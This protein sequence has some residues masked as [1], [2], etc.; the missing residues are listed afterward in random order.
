MAELFLRKIVFQP[1]H[2]WKKHELRHNADF[3]IL[4]S[5]LANIS[6]ND[7]NLIAYA[8]PKVQLDRG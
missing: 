6:E 3:D 8:A 7:N 5:H 2:E 1:P 4:A